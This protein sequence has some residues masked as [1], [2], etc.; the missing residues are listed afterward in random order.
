MR[1]KASPIVTISF[2]L[3]CASMTT[4]GALLIQINAGDSD[5]L[6]TKVEV[7]EDG[8]LLGNAAGTQTSF[9]FSIG[10]LARGTYTF[11]A[12]AYDNDGAITTSSPLV[13]NVGD[14]PTVSISS[15]PANTTF[16]APATISI[17]AVPTV[18]ASRGV[19]RVDFLPGPA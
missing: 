9:S 1:P 16:I 13:I 19:S 11:T 6:V 10:A 5:G 14:G 18:D 12:K 7:Y 17:T 15:P 3:P 4:Q 2:P 8:V